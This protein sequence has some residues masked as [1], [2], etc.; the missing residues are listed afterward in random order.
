[1]KSLFPPADDH[2]Q[3]IYHGDKTHLYDAMAGYEDVENNL[4]RMLQRHTP[5]KAAAVLDVGAGTGR[6]SRLLAPQTARLVSL[7]LNIPML[8]IAQ[9]YQ[10]RASIPWHII[11]GDATRLPLASAWADVV[12]AGWA[13]GHFPGWFDNWIELTDLAINEMQ[14]ALKPGGT[15]ILIETMGTGS[16]SPLPPTEGL[17]AYYRRLETIHHFQSEVIRTDY[18]FPD[19]KTAVEL[20]GFF[21]GDELAHKMQQENTP[22]LIEWTGV[23][24]RK[25]P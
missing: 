8:R 1:M 12:T 16:A 9:R 23:W 11:A 4:L 25:K 24:W 18:A 3:T 13:I 7:D 2:F 22:H 5:A 19:V 20:V 17:A 21:F 15:Q 10:Q 14:R 6:V